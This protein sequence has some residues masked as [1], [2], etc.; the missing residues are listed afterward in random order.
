MSWKNE[1]FRRIYRIYKTDI[2]RNILQVQNNGYFSERIKLERVV[3]QGYLLSFLLHCTQNHVFNYSVN[4]DEAIKGFK[5]PGRK[6]NVKLSQYTDDNSFTSTNFSNIS[7]FF[8]KF[9]KWKEATGC[10][11]NIDK[12]EKLSIQTNR[13]F[14]N[15]SNIPIKWN[16]TT[17]IWKW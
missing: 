12:T 13:A 2:P 16:I 6:E 5:L 1:L 9:S 10:T 7:F 11:L 3:R 15:N 4:K 17:T 14:H 8:G